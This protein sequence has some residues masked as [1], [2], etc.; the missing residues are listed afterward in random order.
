MKELEIISTIKNTL[1]DSSF[2]GDDTAWADGMVFTQDTL[3]ENLHFAFETIS[4]KELGIKALNVNLSDLAAAGAIPCYCLISL[5]LPSSISASFVKEFYEGVER[6]CTKTNLKVLGG[7]ITGGEKV[8][9]SVAMIGK[10]SKPVKR[11]G[12]EIGDVVFVTGEHGNSRIGFEFLNKRFELSKPEKFVKAHLEPVP[13]LLEGQTIIENASDFAM[14]DSSDGLADALFKIAQSSEVTLCVDF[15]KIPI[16]GTFLKIKKAILENW[17]L[18]GGEDYELVGTLSEKD[19]EVISK[20]IKLYKI[21][22]VEKMQ[23]SP[24]IIENASS[25]SYLDEKIIQEHA[26]NHFAGEDEK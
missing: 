7:D 16:D 1:N 25:I 14:M 18:F 24:V 15:Q 11:S 8:V 2:I 22:H 20:K 10:A 4:P 3:V 12:A 21:G 9:I 26:F 13:R 19:F 5:S 23:K 6:V 17:V